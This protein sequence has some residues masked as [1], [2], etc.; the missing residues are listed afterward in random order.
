MKRAYLGIVLDLSLPIADDP[1]AVA[2]LGAGLRGAMR[3]LEQQ[4]HHRVQVALAGAVT[5]AL[6]RYGEERALQM[7]AERASV[8]QVVF[9]STA[10]HG[11]FLPLVPAGEAARQLEL[12][13][14]INREALGEWVFRA[15]GL[16]P[17]QL[18]YTRAVPELA[19]R[20]GLP[21]VLVDDLAYR[22]GIAPLPRNR[23][24]ALQGKANFHIIVV[25]RALSEAIGEGQLLDPEAIAHQLGRRLST[26]AIVRIPARRLLGAAPGLRLLNALDA[27]AALL[28][29]TLEEL[30]ALFPEQEI[31]EPLSCALGTDP[32]ELAAGIPFAKWSAP[33]NELHALLWR[34]AQVAAAEAERLA[35]QPAPSVGYSQLRALL[36]ESLDC[37]AWRFASA[38][39]ELDPRRVLEGGVRVRWRTTALI[40]ISWKPRAVAC[41]I[42]S[43]STSS[44]A[45]WGWPMP[46]A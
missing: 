14:R 15:E 28:P 46:T 18:G 19:Y 5:S 21:R 44:V 4:P 42:Q 20:R 23:H 36:D 11:A 33:G 7:L 6:L 10:N 38:K 31:I 37:A 9:L 2:A 35:Q 32:S 26:Y 22:G 24:F 40:G 39:P 1:S 3:L 43:S 34:L 25:D 8:G 27:H 29:A 12:N 17:P 45:L 41:G 13:E 16:F 30:I